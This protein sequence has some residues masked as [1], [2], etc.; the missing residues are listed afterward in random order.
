MTL[1]EGNNFFFPVL[2][3]VLGALE[4]A[5]CGGIKDFTFCILLILTTNQSS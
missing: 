3:T 1:T 4:N 2:G 5:G